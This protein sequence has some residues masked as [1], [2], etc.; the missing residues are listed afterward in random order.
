MKNFCQ[1][2]CQCCSFESNKDNIKL[3][4]SGSITRLSNSKSK[5][6][7]PHTVAP[8]YHKYTPVKSRKPSLADSGRSIFHNSFDEQKL[9]PVTRL[10]SVSTSI[11]GTLSSINNRQEASTEKTKLTLP[12]QF[13]L[14][15]STP[16]SKNITLTR[17]QSA[18][19][20]LMH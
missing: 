15:T 2:L 6:A 7:E 1:W 20:I 11:L 10:R 16:K 19:A 4:D 3:S 12:I 5:N 9:T 13:T 18:P 17:S 14:W 8:S